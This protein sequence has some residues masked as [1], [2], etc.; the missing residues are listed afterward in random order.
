MKILQSETIDKLAEKYTTQYIEV[1]EF[2]SLIEAITTIKTIIDESIN[3]YWGLIITVAIALISAF[4][5]AW[6]AGQINYKLQ[7]IQATEKE[8]NE[9]HK[10]LLTAWT[11]LIGDLNAIH[12]FKPP[13]MKDWEQGIHTQYPKPHTLIQSFYLNIYFIAINEQKYFFILS[14]T[15]S[16]IEQLRMK[17]EERD[18]LI[19]QRIVYQNTAIHNNPPIQ[20]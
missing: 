9:Q 7:K 12:A 13:I 5:G 14:N 10:I 18:K 8:K 15:A 17:I 6:W 1:D 16:L 3:D 19:E 20:V 4:G 11:Y 2:G